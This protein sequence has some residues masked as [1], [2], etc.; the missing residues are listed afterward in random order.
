ML[1]CNL[2]LSLA[3][4]P[5]SHNTYSQSSNK[6]SSYTLCG[7]LFP[8]IFPGILVYRALRDQRKSRL[9][10][11]HAAIQMTAFICAVVALRTVF[12]SHNLATP[13]PI[14]N[15]YSLHSWVGITTVALFS[16]Q[17]IPSFCFYFLF[18]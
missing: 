1:G 16:I 7:D 14:P 11:L 6:C 2:D 9:K 17:V 12:D 15:L 18:Q 13:K 5:I 4:L 8:L 3:N 10:L